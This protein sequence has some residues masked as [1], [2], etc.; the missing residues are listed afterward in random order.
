MVMRVNTMGGVSALPV[1]G[2]ALYAANG[3]L[4]SPVRSQV[5]VF[6]LATQVR[7]DVAGLGRLSLFG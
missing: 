3:Q 4:F 7:T 1:A 6:D 5:G 2:S